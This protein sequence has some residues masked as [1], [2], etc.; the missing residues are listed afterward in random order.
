MQYRYAEYEATT[1]VGSEATGTNGRS[2]RGY[3]GAAEDKS[4]NDMKSSRIIVSHPM[5]QQILSYFI[6]FVEVLHSS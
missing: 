3:L 6:A 4:D 1:H 2:D 5:V